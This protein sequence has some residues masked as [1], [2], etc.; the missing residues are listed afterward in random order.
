M[1]I[2]EVKNKN[3]VVIRLRLH[4]YAG[5]DAAKKRAIIETIG[6][7]DRFKPTPQDILNKLKDNEKQE[8]ELY[9]KQVKE[10]SEANK[11]LS[12]VVESASVLNNAAV[13]LSSSAYVATDAQAKAIYDAMDKMT[14]ALRKVGHKRVKPPTKPKTDTKTLPLLNDQA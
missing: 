10:K 9:F 11:A 14:K 2:Q 3:G 8:L 1:Q 7:F 5:Y 12:S 4:R 6:A 13:A